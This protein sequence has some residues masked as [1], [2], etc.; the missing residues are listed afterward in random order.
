[1]AKAYLAITSLMFGLAAALHVVKAVQDWPLL[2]IEPAHYLSMAALGAIAALMSLWGCCLLWRGKRRGLIM[3]SFS[4]LSAFIVVVASLVACERQNTAYAEI[5]ADRL[6]A[7]PLQDLRPIVAEMGRYRRWV[8]PKLREVLAQGRESNP[9]RCLRAA[10]GLLP[11]DPSPGEAIFQA[12]LAAPP[13]EARVLIGVLDGQKTRWVEPLWRIIDDDR[14]PAATRLRAAMALAAF[15][16]PAAE[17]QDPWDA[18]AP[19]IVD[20]C[21]AQTRLDPSWYLPLMAA[22]EPARS[23]LVAPF[24]RVFRGGERDATD[25][26]LSASILARYLTD[27]GASLA[28]LLAQAELKQFET[29]FAALERNGGAAARETLQR[30]LH[31]GPHLELTSIDRV[32]LGRRR[33][34]AAAA[35]FRLGNRDAVDDVLRT[36]ED[37]ETRTQFVHRS[38]ELGLSPAALLDCLKRAESLR[39]VNVGETRRA[40]D[41]ALYAVLLALG[42]FRLTDLPESERDSIVEQLAAWHAGDPIA[43]VHGAAGWLLRRW[44]LDGRAND[45]DRTPLDYSPDREW[46]TLE[47]KHVAEGLLGPIAGEQVFHITFIVFTPGEYVIGSPPGE[48]DRRDDETRHSVKLTRP[49]A[50]SDREITWKQYNAID[51]ARRHDALEEQVGR[52][53]AIEE[54]VF[55]VN[56][57]EAVSYCRWLTEIAAMREDD[58]AYAAPWSLVPSVFAP[59]PDPEVG[60]APRNWPLDLDKPGFRLP[61]EA[62]WEV[63]CRWQ[64]TT[65]YSFGNDSKR[66]TNYGWHSDNSQQR[67]H[68][69]GTLRPNAG[70]LFDMH[71]NLYEWC[72]DW[73]GDYKRDVVDPL[74]TATGAYRVAR[75]GSSTSAAA[76][77]RSANRAP[78]EPSQRLQNLGF[79]VVVVPFSRPSNPEGEEH[80][81]E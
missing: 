30:I 20:Q 38:R 76:G 66:L 26:E 3:A 79:R 71:G 22:L 77:C 28:E 44:Q 49:F 6:L 57:Y 39:H 35:L 15:A 69:P 37:P 55:G 75:G 1:M 24:A 46:F 67:L 11:V 48:T 17:N 5:L 64:T 68:P 81:G 42:E 8:D 56:W 29:L 72:H 16:P 62:E 7:A 9:D 58:Q 34:A 4:A 27:D 33:A 31:E 2:E 65:A 41:G 50:V 54:P 51:N 12:M 47:F 61:T 63:A 53:L 43:A 73:H 18:Q 52:T 25:R 21:L 19:F 10:V 36:D 13:D 59:D 32:S 78:I 23:V 45:V 80:F 60:G 70:G 74:G 40:D 14:A